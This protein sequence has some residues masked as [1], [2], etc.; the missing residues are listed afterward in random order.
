M[1][2]SKTKLYIA[3]YKFHQNFNL[4]FPVSDDQNHVETEKQ[5]FLYLLFELP[6]Q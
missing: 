5:T 2:S 4:C 3:I 6:D 1:F